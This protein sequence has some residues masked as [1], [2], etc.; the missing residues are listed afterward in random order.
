MIVSAINEEKTEKEVK[1]ENKVNIQELRKVFNEIVKNFDISASETLKNELDLFINVINTEIKKI[2]NVQSSEM[3]ILLRLKLGCIRYLIKLSSLRDKIDL[4]HQALD[5]EENDLALWIELGLESYACFDLTT[6]LYA[7][8]R[9]YQ[10]YHNNNLVIKYI[11]LINAV[12]FNFEES[13]NVIKKSFELI[14]LRSFQ[15]NMLYF[16]FKICKID[17]II[18]EIKSV[19]NSNNISFTKINESNPE[20]KW[21]LAEYDKCNNYTIEIVRE[22]E[23]LIDSQSVVFYDI[24]TVFLDVCEIIKKNFDEDFSKSKSAKFLQETEE[25]RTSVVRAG[26]EICRSTS[27]DLRELDERFIALFSGIVPIEINERENEEN[28]SSSDSGSELITDQF[29]SSLKQFLQTPRNL[30]RFFVNFLKFIVKDIPISQW[31][32]N[33]SVKY[34]YFFVNIHGKFLI[35]YEFFDSETVELFLRYIEIYIILLSKNKVFAKDRQHVR[36]KNVSYSVLNDYF[37]KFPANSPFTD[38]MTR[39]SYILS[40]CY[41]PNISI[42]YLTVCLEY[43]KNS[44][45]LFSRSLLNQFPNIYIS[46]EKIRTLISFYDYDSLIKT[47]EDFYCRNMF[48]ECIRIFQQNQSMILSVKSFAYVPDIAEFLKIILCAYSNISPEIYN[49]AVFVELLELVMSPRYKLFFIGVFSEENQM[50]INLFTGIFS[51]TNLLNEENYKNILVFFTKILSSTDHEHAFYIKSWYYLFEASFRFLQFR[52]QNFSCF[53]LDQLSDIFCSNIIKCNICC[54]EK[55]KPVL[56]LILRNLKKFSGLEVSSDDDYSSSWEVYI[57]A[58]FSHLVGYPP[59]KKLSSYLG[60]FKDHQDIEDRKV[61]SLSIKYY[62]LA[63]SFFKP[64]YPIN[65]SLVTESI[66]VNSKKIPISADLFKFLEN[67][68]KAISEI[69]FDANKKY[70][71]VSSSVYEKYI[72]GEEKWPNW[73]ANLDSDYKMNFSHILDFSLFYYLIDYSIRGQNYK[74]SL[75]WLLYSISTMPVN[76][77]TWWACASFT[78]FRIQDELTAM[79]CIDGFL[80][81]KLQQ[82][83]HSIIFCYNQALYF[84]KNENSS[85]KQNIMI[86]YGW[87]CYNLSNFLKKGYKFSKNDQD[88]K[89]Q[90]FRNSTSIFAKLFDHFHQN[91]STEYFVTLK[92]HY[93]SQNTFLKDPEAESII[94]NGLTIFEAMEAIDKDIFVFVVIFLFEMCILIWRHP[95]PNIAENLT[96]RLTNF[97]GLI[98]KHSSSESF[99]NQIDNFSQKSNQDTVSYDE[100]ETFTPEDKEETTNLEF[101]KQE[102]IFAPKSYRLTCLFGMF[103]CLNYYRYYSKFIVEIASCLWEF[104]NEQPESIRRTFYKTII[105]FV[106]GNLQPLCNS[107]SSFFTKMFSML[108]KKSSGS[109]NFVGLLNLNN[110]AK[111]FSKCW[112]INSRFM[113]DFVNFPLLISKCLSMVIQ[114]FQKLEDALILI[115]ICTSLNNTKGNTYIFEEDRR[116][117]ID[118][119]VENVYSHTENIMREIDQLSPENLDRIIFIYNKLNSFPVKVLKQYKERIIKN[120]LNLFGRTEY[121]KSL[122]NQL[123]D[124]KQIL[125]AINKY[126]LSFKNKFI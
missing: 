113:D 11:C 109:A 93:L 44:L 89:N 34:C 101:P 125:E 118:T 6:A 1:D 21:L 124:Q 54:S 72:N 70:L 112:L 117:L 120:L 78:F 63:Y 2:E 99:L 3:K 16:L 51:T 103:Q 22:P 123:S 4:L 102:T 36:A 53:F 107:N 100:V 88:F 35:E 68:G 56:F 23:V 9:V 38:L 24:D 92:Y 114:I 50:M 73:I 84:L 115:A 8:Y 119:C 61:N 111:I 66:K 17:K 15:T 96:K 97:M 59:S 94:I 26:R 37:N 55:M 75:K 126:T 18:N 47:C 30:K 42:A 76:Y 7:F 52:D 106:S 122:Q 104:A 79:N 45:F 13:I 105:Y 87:F 83:I 12:I 41:K 86:D 80:P 98:D 71:S 77:M 25:L 62:D 60:Y 108:K 10:V 32:M 46:P 110:R 74:N 5:I 31:N 82:L 65:F 90:I 19:C 39:I 27:E 57:E 40:F 58:M 95:R 29:I 14:N 69:I 116:N 28:E 64:T 20:I 85:H 81:P 49:M 48:L 67:F 33:L 121:C 91:F 43:H